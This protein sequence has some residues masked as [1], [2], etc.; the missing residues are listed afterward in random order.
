MPAEIPLPLRTVYAELLDR[1]AA[2]DFGGAFPRDGA[3]VAKTV[4]GRRYWYVQDA[5]AMGRKQRYVGPETPDLLERITRHQE[6]RENQHDLRALVSTLV[7]SALLPRPLPP[8]GETV[9]ALADAGVFRL[10]GVLVG[11]IAYQT[12]SAMLGERLPAALI[13]T[14]DVDIAQFADVSVAV[15]DAT[16]PIANV[17]KRVNSTFRPVPHLRGP[18]YVT[19]FKATR[20]LRVEFLTPNRGAETDEPRRL[21][22]FGID[23]HPFRFLD[24]LIR[25][26]EPAV[27]LHGT[28]V[29]VSV[30]AP[31]RFAL[32][33]LIVA[34]RR[35]VGAAKSEKDIRQATSLLDV[36]IRQRPYELRAAWQETYARGPAW[37]R[38]LGEGLGAVRPDVRDRTLKLVDIPRA[39]IPGLQLQ[40]EA[41]AVGYDSDRD[42]AFWYGKAGV[43]GIRCAISREALEDHF[44]ADGLDR[45]GRLRKLRENR[46]TFEHFARIKYLTWPI[47]E[48]GSI[49]IG[50]ADIDVLR[51]SLKRRDAD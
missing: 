23:A 3:F 50:S 36:L 25:E 15:G 16:A 20:G 22:A 30:P 29:F 5:T 12:Y 18:E 45:A 43:E 31:Q 2:A 17:L 51:R 28:G 37:R 14:D 7:R 1:A 49:L 11:T 9:A 47:D 21:P 35:P 44:G 39:F 46:P 41:P 24:F 6:A 13:Q 42:V 40:F 19:A 27:L 26:P 34:R 48:P 33:K 32:H 10:R 38:L 4:R 8:V